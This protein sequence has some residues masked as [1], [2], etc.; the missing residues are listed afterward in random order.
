MSFSLWSST[1]QS[2]PCLTKQ[3]QLTID[4]VIK[5]VNRGEINFDDKKKGTITIYSELY[6]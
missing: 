6:M 2:Y 3:S 1:F 5:E 4:L